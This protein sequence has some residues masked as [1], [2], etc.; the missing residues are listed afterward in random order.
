[1]KRLSYQ[2]QYNIVNEVY[3]IYCKKLR[4]YNSVVYLGKDTYYD[5]YSYGLCYEFGSI[6][7]R[8]RYSIKYNRMNDT[9]DE[10]ITIFQKKYALKYFDGQDKLYW[11]PSRL[12][13]DTDT[14]VS[15][16]LL[17]RLRFLNWMRMELKYRMRSPIKSYIE[18]LFGISKFTKKK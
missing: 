12:S 10:F 16:T 2:Q 15:A 1:M 7:H 4:E 5:Y 14:P 9:I 13:G 11:W 8:C 3:D 18:R 6:L 17:P